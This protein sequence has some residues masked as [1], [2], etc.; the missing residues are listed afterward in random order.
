MMGKGGCH[1][2]YNYQFSPLFLSKIAVV[3]NKAGYDIKSSL[4]QVF[5]VIQKYIFPSYD[6][7]SQVVVELIFDDGAY[8][9]NEKI[10]WNKIRDCLQILSTNSSQICILSSF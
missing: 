9:N 10:K 7:T 3:Q 5:T 1:L 8:W 2:C 6:N 4:W